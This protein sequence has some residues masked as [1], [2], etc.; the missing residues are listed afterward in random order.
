MCCDMVV[1][2][3]VLRTKCYL[4]SHVRLF[5]TLWTVVHQAPLFVEFWN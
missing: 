2:A 3:W 4:L 5:A 1:R